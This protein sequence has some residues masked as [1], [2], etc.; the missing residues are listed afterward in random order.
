MHEHEHDHDHDHNAQRSVEP[1][2]EIIV[3][4]DTVDNAVVLSCRY[5]VN[6]DDKNRTTR[7]LKAG[8]LDFAEQIEERGGIIGHIKASLTS[9]RVDFISITDSRSADVQE[10]GNGNVTIGLAAILFGVSEDEAREL[11]SDVLTK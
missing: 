7:A 5:L 1:T 6:T 9:E 3:T 10:S 11:L 4:S 2:Y 8:L